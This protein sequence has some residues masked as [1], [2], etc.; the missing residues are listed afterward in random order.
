MTRN[1]NKNGIETI[2]DHDDLFRTSRWPVP[3]QAYVPGG[4]L[5]AAMA[6]AWLARFPGGM[7]DWGVSRAALADGHFAGIAL[8]MF[9]HGGLFHIMMNVIVLVTIS[10]PLI[11]RLGSP[12]AAWLRYAAL[13]GL[14]GLAGMT[15]YLLLQPHG[16]VPMVG[17]S[18][19][20]YGLF[21][22]LL[23]LQHAG[24]PPAPIRSRRTLLAAKDFV[25]DNL[26]LF[27]LL[28]LPAWLDGRGG[29]VA[30]QAHLG[31]FLFGLFAGPLFLPRRGA[32]AY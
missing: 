5:G 18:G 6:A 7:T 24:A 26:L 14:S 2:V 30:W 32:T 15:A 10:G 13:F 12:P 29:G 22:L 4:L 19:A 11:A 1:D 20:I 3:W 27:A 28:T 31:G 21:G 23:R 8:H 16:D 17:A 9:A 25:K